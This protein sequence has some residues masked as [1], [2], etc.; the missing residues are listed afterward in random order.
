MRAGEASIEKARKSG[1]RAVAQRRPKIGASYQT[2]S[3]GLTGKNGAAEVAFEPPNFGRMLSLVVPSTLDAAK[4][5][6]ANAKANAATAKLAFLLMSA[7]RRWTA[8][9]LQQ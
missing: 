2:G 4:R 1:T 7:S 3:S 8:Q 5:I 9:Q 6:I